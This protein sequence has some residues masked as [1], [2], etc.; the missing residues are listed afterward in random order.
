MT[1]PSPPNELS[2]LEIK[3]GV[4][5]DWLRKKAGPL[6]AHSNGQVFPGWEK[7]LYS[8]LED[9]RNKP[10]VPIALVG[11]TGSGKSTLLNALLG[12]EVLPVSNM[13]PCTAVVTSVRYSPAA[14]YQATVTFL[15]RQAWDEELRKLKDT[16]QPGDREDDAEGADEWQVISRSTKDKICAVYGLD[17]EALET[18]PGLDSLHLDAQ[19]AGCLQ[20]EGSR[21]FLEA[22][23]TK[24]LKQMDL[25]VSKKL[26]DKYGE[27]G[28]TNIKNQTN[29][30][31]ASREEIMKALVGK[32]E[33]LIDVNKDAIDAEVISVNKQ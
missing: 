2:P 28:T 17:K 27:G 14:V 15:S 13:K 12:A 31:V 9:V 1:Q 29:I 23:S 22:A 11:S 19:M 30:L 18:M 33:V 8:L 10:I 20:G 32:A 3:I 7:R 24:E 6:L 4:F 25:D 21:V 5:K 16:F 26:M